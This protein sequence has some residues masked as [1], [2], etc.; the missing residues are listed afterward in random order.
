MKRFTLQ[1]ALLFAA[2]SL[3]LS[4]SNI[5]LTTG[6][7]NGPLVTS[8]FPAAAIDVATF[9]YTIPNGEFIV[10]A[11]FS[12]TFG[13]SSFANSAGV[14]VFVGGIAV[15]S[16]APLASCDTGNAVTPFSYTF[17]PADFATLDSGSVTVTAVQRS[18][19]IIR[20]GT[21]SLNINTASATPEPAS[22]GLIGA[23][24][25]GLAWVRRKRA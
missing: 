20:L 22:F 17:Q 16:C 7:F 11:S 8:G 21:E 15:G 19:N 1:F 23:G 9:N 12:S 4:A 2:A 14:D 5:T 25:A 18:G 3:T 24:L 6:E 13:N 10:S